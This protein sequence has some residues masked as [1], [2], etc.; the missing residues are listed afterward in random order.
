MEK[1]GMAYP[2][3]FGTGKGKTEEESKMKRDE[4]RRR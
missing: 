2:T 1:N 4:K 3:S